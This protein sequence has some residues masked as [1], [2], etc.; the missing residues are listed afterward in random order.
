[1]LLLPTV[2][3]VGASTKFRPET[4][5]LCVSLIHLLWSIVLQYTQ[6]KKRPFPI[7]EAVGKN[8]ITKEP[9]GLPT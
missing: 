3:L 9:E 6:E 1:M 8:V 2:L 7:L 5:H 4:F